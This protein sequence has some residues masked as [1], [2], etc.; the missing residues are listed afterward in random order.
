M[1]RI[2]GLIRNIAG[3]VNILALNATIEAARAGEQGRGFAVVAFEVRS[4]A[5]RSADLQRDFPVRGQRQ[6][7]QAAG[8]FGQ[9]SAIADEHLDGLARVAGH[10]GAGERLAPQCKK[11]PQRIGRGIAGLGAYLA[12]GVHGL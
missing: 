6:S 4:L 8:V 11:L 7:V 2:V 3:R 12:A 5:G 1:E 9:R 10:I